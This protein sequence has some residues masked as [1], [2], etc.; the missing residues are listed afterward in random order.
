LIP[1]APPRCLQVGG[2]CLLCAL[3]LPGSAAYT[4]IRFVVSVTC[5]L[6]AEDRDQLRNP[7]LVSS[8]GLGYFY[9]RRSSSPKIRLA[10]LG[11]FA[12]SGGVS[13][14]QCSSSSYVHPTSYNHAVAPLVDS[15]T[16]AY[17][18]SSR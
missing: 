11:G 4:T 7:T 17:K 12:V 8:M 15:L 1:Y 6:I 10:V 18:L 2:N 9:L 16:F 13:C 5:G 3:P 14:T